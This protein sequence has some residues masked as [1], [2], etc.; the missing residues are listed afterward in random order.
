MTDTKHRARDHQLFVRANDA[1]GGPTGVRR[2]HV[3]RLRIARRVQLNA[4]E[5]QPFADAL[6]DERCM[7]AD[8]SCKDA[9]SRGRDRRED[10]LG[11]QRVQQGRT[12]TPRSAA[13][14]GRSVGGVPAGSLT[15]NVASL[16]PMRSI[17]PFSESAPERVACPST[18]PASN[19]ANRMLDDPPLNTS[20][21]GTTAPST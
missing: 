4:Q 18:E 2:N 13:P 3:R 11:L 6:A 12:A 17:S 20:T 21:Q 15:M 16:D 14:K 1:N 8:T 5:D 19:T 7:F 10:R 9:A